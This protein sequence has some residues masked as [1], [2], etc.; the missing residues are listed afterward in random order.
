MFS[1]T[2]PSFKTYD[3]W[4]NL[5]YTVLWCSALPTPPKMRLAPKGIKRQ[6]SLNHSPDIFNQQ[7]I[8]SFRW[9]MMVKW[10]NDG[11]LQDNEWWWML[12]DC[13]MSVW[14]YTHFT[15][16]SEHFIIIDEHFTI[17]NEQLTI[18]EKLH[19]LLCKENYYF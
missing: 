6:F 9:S 2:N 15:I 10:G 8:I 13:E 16:I 1:S 14:S 19:R 12:N 17:I 5:N 3:N 18:I 4:L 11:W 7:G